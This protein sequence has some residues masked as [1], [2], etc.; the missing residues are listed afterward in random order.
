MVR[1]SDWNRERGNG[2]SGSLEIA[3]PCEQCA[4]KWTVSTDEY[5]S[6]VLFARGGGIALNW[7]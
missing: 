6:S 3:N 4:F 2:L 7:R 5:P 1:S